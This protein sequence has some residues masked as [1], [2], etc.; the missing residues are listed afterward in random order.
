[1]TI[2]R[3]GI[4]PAPPASAD[5]VVRPIKVSLR[6]EGIGPGPAREATEDFD[7]AAAVQ[8]TEGLREALLAG[9]SDQERREAGD[10]LFKLL[11]PGPVGPLWHEAQAC[12]TDQEPLRVCLE[13]EV[14]DLHSMPWELLRD[15]GTW[16]FH[17]PRMLSS[18]RHTAARSEPN[19]DGHQSPSVEL[20]PLRVLVVVC[21]PND[22][23][24]LAD[25]EIAR[26]G[27]TLGMRHGRAHLQVLDGPSHENLFDE[28]RTWRPHILHFIG[29]G[30]PAVPGAPAKL[31]FNWA[32]QQQSLPDA[33]EQWSLTSEDVTEL[34]DEWQPR[35]VVLNACRTAADTVDRLGG[36]ARAFLEAGVGAVVSMQ[37]DIDSPASVVFARA[38]YAVL[39]QDGAVDQAVHAARRQLRDKYGDKGWWA[40]PVLTTRHGPEA[41][42][43]IRPKPTEQAIARLCRHA[44]YSELDL[45]VDRADERRVAWRALGVTEQPADR[46]VLVVSGH[47]QTGCRHT[48]KTWL[49][50]SCLLS[51][52]V[53]GHR[54]T[55]V[56]LAGRIPTGTAAEPGPEHKD[57]LDLLRAIRAA[58]MDDSQPEPLPPDAFSTFNVTLN[59]LVE[60][61]APVTAEAQELVTDQWKPFNEQVG[62][63]D[64]RRKRIFGAFLDALRK[65]SPERVHVL[66][67][68][69][70]EFLLPTSCRNVVH[71]EL[72]GPIARDTESPLRLILVATEDWISGALPAEDSTL[73]KKK[74]LRLG[75]FK[76]DEFMR[77]A[78]EYCE[79]AGLDFSLAKPLL[80]KA[81]EYQAAPVDV[82][83]E[84]RRLLVTL[85]GGQG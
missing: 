26:C 63:A 7:L 29:H 1:M 83:R 65:A 55:Y 28:V 44:L 80:E 61:I 64:Q 37:A 53:H 46:Q 2:A 58:C 16:L 36:L 9:A 74:P 38:L 72:I 27:A 3:F 76:I 77:L 18:R 56:D 35:L 20:G 50:R 10:C 33:E 85:T 60:G 47:S 59:A 21:N 40:L 66:A 41:A 5:T 52:F 68:D 30:M 73:W 54:I 22:R 78:E 6:V 42:L 49:T 4:R 62:Q 84:A 71:P 57:W 81:Y 14:E 39:T 23:H 51:C 75:D 12:G 48:G 32:T 24:Q 34:L 25:A 8:R 79:R 17:H 13:I 43:A 45:F 11:T 67:L 70:A 82:F 15:Q 31:P 69:H 19:T